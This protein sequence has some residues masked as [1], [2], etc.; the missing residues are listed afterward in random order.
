[1]RVAT[2]FNL[3]VQRSRSVLIA[4]VT[5]PIAPGIVTYIILAILQP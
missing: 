5:V 1:M 3:L 2:K 4:A